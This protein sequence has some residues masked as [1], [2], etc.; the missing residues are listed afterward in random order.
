VLPYYR[1]AESNWRG[2][3]RFHGA[4]GPLTTSHHMP[5]DY[6]YPRIIDTAETLGFRHLDDFH[7]EEGEGF[8]TPDFNIHAGTRGSTVARY[9][10]PAMS[11]PNLEVRVNTLVHR[12]V[13]V[14]GRCT[15]VDVEA[16]GA[17]SRT[18]RPTA[19]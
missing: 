3:S 13:L 18:C 6:I 11:R 17:A 1:R 8:S 7:G 2:A 12:L 9:L 19:R 15:G 5:D 4:Q 14:A 10:R 16:A